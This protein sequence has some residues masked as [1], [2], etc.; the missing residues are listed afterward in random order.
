MEKEC[1]MRT[2]WCIFC[3][4]LSHPVVFWFEFAELTRSE[5]IGAHKVCWIFLNVFLLS[6]VLT[7]GRII[8]VL[9]LLGWVSVSYFVLVLFWWAMW[10]TFP[11]KTLIMVL[12]SIVSFKSAFLH[13]LREHLARL[14]QP[15]QVIDQLPGWERV[16]VK[17][18][19]LSSSK[20]RSKLLFPLKYL[21]GCASGQLPIGGGICRHQA[22]LIGSTVNAASP[23]ICSGII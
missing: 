13:K 23:I 14:G 5:L 8:S 7:L 19:R 16:P 9:F 20:G 10:N 12:F 21:K 22:L 17:V 15:F 18:G 11:V 3:F 2:L 4:F 6:P 1:R